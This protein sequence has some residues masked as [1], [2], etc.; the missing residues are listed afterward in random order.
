[1]KVCQA[2]DGMK[3][4]PNCVYVIPPNVDLSILHGKFQLLEPS[5]PRGLRLPIDFFFKHLAQD[6]KERSVG[7][8]L[9]GMGTD[10][11]QGLKAIK[12]GMGLVLAQDPAS[13]KY[14]GM[15]RSAIGTGLVDIVAP[16]MD[17]PARLAG[18]VKHA[19]SLPH[20]AVAGE[21]EPSSALEKVFVLL[22]ARTGTDFSAYKATTIHRRLE[23]R[24]NV[25]QLESLAHYV[26]Y[27]QENPQ[28]LDLL[29]RELLI[30]VTSF[31]RDPA[32]YQVLQ[33]KA[34]P[35]LLESK[36]PGSPLRVWVPGCATGEEAYSVMLALT[37]CL[38]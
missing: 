9:S 13:A 16:A 34:I 21:A 20:Q 1:M 22:R 7:I 11:T 33:E 32:A 36:A 15:P 18:F 6:Q 38:D 29:F 17:L 10:G 8:I 24:L 25:H 35:Q 12:E 23:R 19:G 2:E 14:D 4:R 28:E 5:A 37:E 26:R 31:F 27:L 3:A 30:G